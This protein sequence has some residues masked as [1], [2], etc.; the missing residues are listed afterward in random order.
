M[1]VSR[2]PM[3]RILYPPAVSL[4]TIGS[5]A[6][7]PIGNPGHRRAE[8]IISGVTPTRKARTNGSKPTSG[9]WSTPRSPNTAAGS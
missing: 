4:R 6:A 5:S 3:V 1:V 7:E 9:N 2:G 8:S